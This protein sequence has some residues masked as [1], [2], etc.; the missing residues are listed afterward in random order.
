LVV[1]ILGKAHSRSDHAG[2]RFFGD[3]HKIFCNYFERNH[4]AIQIGNGDGNVP[5][6]KLT[7]HDRPDRVQLFCNTLIDNY[8]GGNVGKSMKAVELVVAQKGCC[9]DIAMT[10]GSLNW[11]NSSY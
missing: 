1:V 3:D 11:R 9:R 8:Y 7:S 5:P 6:D 4:P 10:P 2:L